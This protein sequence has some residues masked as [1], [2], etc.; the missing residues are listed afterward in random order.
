MP[1]ITPP[2]TPYIA[3][4]GTQFLPETAKQQ[5]ALIEAGQAAR[6]ASKDAL[7]A[8]RKPLLL[9]IAAW[10]KSRGQYGGTRDEFSAFSGRPMQS[11]CSPILHLLQD[12]ELVDTKVRRQ[13]RWGREATVFVHRDYAAE[14]VIARL[15][16]VMEALT[17]G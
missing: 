17:N 15:P 16:E 8:K 13:T 10:S 3:D 14:D 5:P 9:E 12:G 2:V 7:R 11:V 6:Q 4:V 1:G